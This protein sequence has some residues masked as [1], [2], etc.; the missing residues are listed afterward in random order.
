MHVML[1]I[2]TQLSVLM[3]EYVKRVHRRQPDQEE[4]YHWKTDC[5]DYPRRGKETLM[6][7]KNEPLHIQPCP[8][9]TQLDKDERSQRE[10][11][12]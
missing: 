4:Y 5:P 6:I 2:I 9:C 3:A 7:F 10:R 1:Y 11:A 8:R 12:S